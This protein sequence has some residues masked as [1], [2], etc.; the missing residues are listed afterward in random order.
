[1]IGLD[2]VSIARIDEAI[3]KWGSKFL[4]KFLSEAE[5]TLVKTNKTA[6]GFWAAKEAAAKALGCGI[7]KD[8]TFHDMQLQKTDLGSPYITLKQPNNFGIEKIFISI[9]HDGGFAA[10]VAFIEKNNLKGF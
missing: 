10:A 5:I 1:M 2:I 8:L 3:K 7:C 4:N 6:A 9:T